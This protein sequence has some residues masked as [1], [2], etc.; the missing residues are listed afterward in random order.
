MGIAILFSA[1]GKSS[2]SLHELHHR[3][4]ALYYVILRREKKAMLSLKLLLGDRRRRGYNGREV[5]S[6]T[7]CLGFWYG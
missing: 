5:Y 6:I 7:L 4:K 2:H 1:S 3:K